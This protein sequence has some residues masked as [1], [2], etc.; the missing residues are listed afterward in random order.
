MGPVILTCQE[1]AVN[2]DE[3]LTVESASLAEGALVQRLLELNDDV[4]AL[5]E[6]LRRLKGGASLTELRLFV[7]SA[8]ELQAKAGI[9]QH[10]LKKEALKEAG[11]PV[12]EV[13]EARRLLMAVTATEEAASQCRRC[14]AEARHASPA[15]ELR[16]LLASW[17]NLR[18]FGEQRFLLGFCW[19]LRLLGAR[20]LCRLRCH[21]RGSIVSNPSNVTA[22]TLQPKQSEL[23]AEFGKGAAGRKPRGG[24]GGTHPWINSQIIQASDGR[25]VHHLM[26]VIMQHL[27]QMNL[28]NLS[29]AIHRVAKIAGSDPWQQAQLRKNPS[30]NTLLNSVCTALNVVEAT[31]VQPQSVSNV[32]WSLATLRIVHRPLLQV[33]SLV[34]ISNMAQFKS[35]ELSTT[36]WA[37]AKLGSMEDA[38]PVD[39]A[40]FYA[41]AT[42]IHNNVKEFGFRCLATTAWA[43]ATSRQR[44]ARLF[45]SMAAAMLPAAAG[46]NC[47]E[48]ANTAWAFGTA[49]FHDDAL[50]NEL[51]EQALHRLEEFKPQE[52]SNMLW[53]FA[54]NSFFHEAFYARAALVAQQMELQSQHLA[55]ILWAFARVRPKHALTQQTVLSL[56]PLCTKQLQSFKPQEVSSTLLASA[57]AVGNSDELAPA[58]ATLESFSP[59]VLDFFH[60][61]L[62]WVVARMREFSEQSLANSVSAYAMV[63]VKGSD[64]LV[65]CAGKEVLGRLQELDVNA[66]VHLLKGFMMV[67]T[68]N[69][70]QVIKVLAE[71]IAAQL[72]RVR[73]Q[74]MQSLGR[75][76]N[77]G[78]AAAHQRELERDEIRARLLGLAS[79]Q[80][81]AVT[82]QAQPQV[83]AQ[84]LSQNVHQNLVQHLPAQ[85]LSMTSA[86]AQAFQQAAN[87]QP[88]QVLNA[89]NGSGVDIFAQD[90]GP[91]G[92]IGPRAVGP[93][94]LD[95]PVSIS[96][97]PSVEARDF[98]LRQAARVP[99]LES[100]TKEARDFDLQK[101]SVATSLPANLTGLA[102]SLTSMAAPPLPA[103]VASGM[104]LQQASMMANMMQQDIF[105]QARRQQL[106]SIRYGS[107]NASKPALQEDNFLHQHPLCPISESSMMAALTADRHRIENRISM[108][109]NA[110]P[111]QPPEDGRAGLRMDAATGVGLMPLMPDQACAQQPMMGMACN[112][113]AA[114]Y[115]GGYAAMSLMH[116][117]QESVGERSLQMVPV[118]DQT[119]ASRHRRNNAD[120]SRTLFVKNSFLHVE[121]SDDEADDVNCDGTS[122]DVPPRTARARC[123][124]VWAATMR[125]GPGA[126]CRLQTCSSCSTP[127]ATSERKNEPQALQQVPSWRHRTAMAS[128]LGEG[129]TCT[130]GLLPPSAPVE[131]QH[132]VR[133]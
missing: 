103:D 5:R 63:P 90:P 111:S 61:C 12:E 78:A 46:A 122:Q 112:S 80:A 35:F 62:P 99:H 79:S 104:N 34:C 131:A 53:G 76:F 118:Q 4:V 91:I 83:L 28:V 110:A 132:S 8:A 108:M 113:L 82:S 109:E 89:F 57:K 60:A 30:L 128:Q 65:E 26:S 101:A 43:F 42:H 123:P 92:P 95:S 97:R 71:G 68:N 3:T 10:L 36:L 74:E 87:Q 52:I 27:P 1:G 37:L 119:F 55:N 88:P 32:V 58:P 64:T 72:D 15:S 102:N 116:G 21:L 77:R 75:L 107:K 17:E 22:A 11:I 117:S 98:D 86:A 106:S 24:R 38:A 29:T 73:T 16:Q 20:S 19:Q 18:T 51:A 70:M 124:A 66:L 56:L 114:N 54:T 105:P 39:K 81:P 23:R 59:E 67:P 49:D 50:F 127:S 14:L 93:V 45:R 41:A 48:M 120:N 69:R 9:P 115:P 31:E 84:T 125:I 126:S 7:A 40:V 25:D 130:A 94:S 47:Q 129:E 133:S 6:E 44:H 96:V 85:C 2:L 13:E 33:I 100:K 121:D